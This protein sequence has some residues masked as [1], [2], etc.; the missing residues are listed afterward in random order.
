MFP[1][2]T[3]PTYR[4]ESQEAWTMWEAILTLPFRSYLPTSRRLSKFEWLSSRCAW[5]DAWVYLNKKICKCVII[6]LKTK[7]FEHDSCF[8]EF[9]YDKKLCLSVRSSCPKQFLAR[10]QVWYQFDVRQNSKQQRPSVLEPL[11]FFALI[12]CNRIFWNIRNAD[13]L[14]GC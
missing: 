6:T 3:I 10:V 9:S 13:H 4:F 5:I 7:D 1:T 12:A 8:R 11:V 2:P 14:S